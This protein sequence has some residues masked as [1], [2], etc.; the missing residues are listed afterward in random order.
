MFD[1]ETSIP[2]KKGEGFHVLEFG[3]FVVEASS[4]KETGASFETLVHHNYAKILIS[5]SSI[6]IPPHPLRPVR[7]PQEVL[8]SASRRAC[9]RAGGG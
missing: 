7:L 2:T 9:S 4:L 5:D 3:A 8:D 6:I 1:L